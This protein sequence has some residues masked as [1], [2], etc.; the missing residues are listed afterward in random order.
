MKIE[1]IEL[2]LRLTAFARDGNGVVIGSPGVGKSYTLAEVRENLKRNNVLHLIIPVERLGT[3][4]D[5]EVKMFFKRDGDFIELLRAAAAKAN[6]PAILIFDGFDAARGESERAGV[7]RLIRRGVNELRGQ[8]NTI[9]SVRTFDARKSQ[10]LLELFPETKAT[11]VAGSAPC[12]QFLIP[13]LQGHEVA[14]ALVQVPGLRVLHD[15]G[16][17]AFRTLLTVPFNLWLIERVLRAGAK[18]NEFSEVTS[19]VQL[20][21]MFW[22]YRVRKAAH[23]EDREFI[24]TKAA[25]AM[26]E[27]HTLTVRRDRIYQPQVR[28]AWEGLLSDEI[29]TEVPDRESALAFTHNILFDFAVSAHL[30]ESDPKKLAG[31]VGE[32]PARPLFLRP[33]LV[34]HFTRLWHFNRNAFWHNFSGCGSTRGNAPSPNCSFGCS[35][36]CGQQSADPS[37][38]LTVVGTIANKP[39]TRH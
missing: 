37:G 2:V 22:E 25:R 39:D 23:S 11:T 10:R 17:T 1:R 28:E 36:C 35:C 14:Q 33:S 16:T 4:S 3:A 31:F 5:A 6:A 30:L 15:S 34:Y 24:L 19:E 20:L 13:A 32:E 27:S 38:S 12:R 29:I 7:L 18:A 21:E 9:V 8:W 26:V